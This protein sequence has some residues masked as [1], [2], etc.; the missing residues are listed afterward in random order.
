MLV[1]LCFVLELSHMCIHS[2]YDSTTMDYDVAMLRFK[3]PLKHFNATMSPVCLPTSSTNFPKGNLQFIH[4]PGEDEGEGVGE[5][6][7]LKPADSVSDTKV[8][9]VKKT[10]QG[11]QGKKLA[12]PFAIYVIV[13]VRFGPT[14]WVQ[15]DD[16]LRPGLMQLLLSAVFT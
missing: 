12:A 14:I 5:G 3:T 6:R 16:W 10:L 2:K 1:T 13:C 8:H 7:G 15:H 9:F 4:H 11:I